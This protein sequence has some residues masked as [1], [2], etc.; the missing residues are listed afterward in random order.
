MDNVVLKGQNI[1]KTFFQPEEFH[2]IDNVNVSVK[3][4]EFVTIMGKSGCGKS[5]LLYILSTLDTD[6]EGAVEINGENVSGWSESK[7][8]GFRNRNIGFVFQFHFLLPEFT[9]LENVIMPALKLR[10]YE[11][12][13][14][15]EDGM[16]RL[17]DLN[18]HL[19]A[20][21]LASR[22]SGGQQQ[23]VAIAR[24]L[25]NNPAILLADEPTGNLDSTNSG[26]VLDIFLDLAKQGNTIIAV[27]HDHDFARRSDRI[28]EM[29]DGKLIG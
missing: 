29:S 16:K 3:K 18:L 9:V 23:R 21:K 7:L 14:I 25:I 6:Y 5:T 19:F 10:K 27:T 20:D 24:A 22:L 15:E 8:A 28:V 1:N 11:R 4:G 2:V 13:K 17:Q 26:N 12:R